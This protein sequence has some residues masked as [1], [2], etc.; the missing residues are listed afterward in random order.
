MKK[1]YGLKRAKKRAT[2]RKK[3]PSLYASIDW[4]KAANLFHGTAQLHT[5][6]KP[7]SAQ[8]VLSALAV[9]AEKGLI[10]LAHG[11]NPAVVEFLHEGTGPLFWRSRHIIHRFQKQKYVTIEEKP[12]GTVVVKITRHGLVRAL[13]YQLDTMGLKKPHRWDQKW[14]LIIFDVPEKYHRMRDVFRRRLKQLGLYAL[15][16][17][18]YISP[19][20]C[21]D[22]VEFLRELYGIA[23]TVRYLLVEKVENDAFLRRHFYLS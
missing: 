9:V 5:T 10:F 3:R 4:K 11:D 1:E 2:S 16:E 21:F 19:Y 14:R 8:S 17:S 22:E 20:P 18:V 15:Q 13:G 12:N 7:L 6:H 23:F